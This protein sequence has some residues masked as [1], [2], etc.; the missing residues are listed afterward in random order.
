VVQ[1]N[2]GDCEVRRTEGP[3]L[4]AGEQDADLL[5]LTRGCSLILVGLCQQ[6][7]EIGTDVIRR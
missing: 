3:G 6:A 1:G 5:A 7:R 2:G 4:R